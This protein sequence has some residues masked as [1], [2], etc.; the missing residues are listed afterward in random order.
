MNKVQ[1]VPGGGKIC[2]SYGMPMAKPE[3]F[4]TNADGSP[5]SEYCRYCFQNGEFT[6]K[7]EMPEFIEMQVKIAMEK[8]GMPEE[9]AREMAEST[10]PKLKRW[11]S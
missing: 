5:S 2:Q 7:M 4:G 10:I 8:F 6:A 11:R 9:K 3:D 1:T